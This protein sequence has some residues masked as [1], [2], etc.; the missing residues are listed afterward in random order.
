MSFEK[1]HITIVLIMLSALVFNSCEEFTEWKTQ[2]DGQHLVIDALI[3][4][5]NRQ[6]IVYAYTS[7]AKLNGLPE[8]VSGIRVKIRANLTEVS[9]T[10]NPSTAGEYLSDQNFS[11][12]AG[13]EYEMTIAVDDHY[14]TA[15]SEVVGISPMEPIVIIPHGEYYRIV[16]SESSS[17][18]MMEIFYDW[19]ADSLFSDTYGS[20]L[21]SETFYTLNNIDV[22]RLFAP[23]K[24]VI[25]FPK[26]T[27]I[28]RRKFS[29]NYDHQQ[30]IRSL[31]LET[32]WRGGL[33]DT[34]PGN[35]RTNFRNG[36]LGW[37]GTCMVL[38][39]TTR[40]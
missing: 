26:G 14:D 33:F 10:E 11:V 17:P 4:N 18:S 12:A 21:A 39:D 22:S 23:E 7:N 24:Q 29:L 19:S 37:F 8:P 2:N 13:V 15:Y 38:T 9:F 5:E 25:Y 20:P 40:F 32:E 16:Y 35:V 28:V 30:F 3:T 27:S 34:E 36:T 6:H 1:K 31:L